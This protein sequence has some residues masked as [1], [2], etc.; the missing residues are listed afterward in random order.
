MIQL[1]NR[2]TA[3]IIEIVHH[4]MPFHRNPSRNPNMFVHVLEWYILFETHL[5]K[6]RSWLFLK[7]WDS[8][9]THAYV[10]LPKYLPT[11][12]PRIAAALTAA[13]PAV[14]WTSSHAFHRNCQGAARKLQEVSRQIRRGMS[15]WD[16]CYIP[17]QGIVHGDQ[18]LLIADMLYMYAA[19]GLAFW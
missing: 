12:A 4:I 13:G 3:V 1:R 15:W 10:H 9:A 2:S 19:K 14:V 11:P 17:Y 16:R 8:P 6:K 18:Y 7:S 5:S